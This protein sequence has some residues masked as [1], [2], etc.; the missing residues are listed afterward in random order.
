MLPVAA[1]LAEV[2]AV[3]NFFLLDNLY[4]SCYLSVPLIMQE[5]LDGI[6]CL[7]PVPK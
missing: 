5:T 2:S 3:T 7:K 6:Y 1:E 4:N